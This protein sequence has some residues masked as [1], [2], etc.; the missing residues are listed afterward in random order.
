ML[1]SRVRYRNSFTEPQIRATHFVP[2]FGQIKE[3][4]SFRR[5]SL[6]GKQDVRREWGLVCA[7][8]NMM[9]LSRADG[10]L[11]MAQTARKW[12]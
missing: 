10:V 8:I 2:V 11:E 9:K 12:G 3:Q 4:R 5:L 1:W 7:V 6:R